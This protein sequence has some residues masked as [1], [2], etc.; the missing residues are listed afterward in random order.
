MEKKTKKRDFCLNFFR[1]VVLST[2]RLIAFDRWLSFCIIA[3]HLQSSR[4]QPNG[5]FDT[6]Q[7][8]EQVIKHLVSQTI[9]L[10]KFF[11]IIAILS[12]A[13]VKWKKNLFM[14]F[15]LFRPS[16]VITKQVTQTTN[17]FAMMRWNHDFF[18]NF[19]IKFSLNR[20]SWQKPGDFDS[21]IVPLNM[22]GFVL[23]CHR[24]GEADLSRWCNSPLTMRSNAIQ[25][26]FGC[27]A[28]PWWLL[29]TLWKASYWAP[30]NTF[31]LISPTQ[32]HFCSLIGPFPKNYKT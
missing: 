4:C 13:K 2:P 9:I 22:A 28:L 23:E 14:I 26:W 25:E 30:V 10:L 19:S 6:A 20:Q 17:V 8:I 16:L 1:K 12:L 32:S 29:Q 5:N 21:M 7:C 11:I 27:W 24:E 18:C 31:L 15:F 3:L